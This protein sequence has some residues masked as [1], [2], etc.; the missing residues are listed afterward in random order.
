[1]AVMVLIR[2]E[3][4][5]QW[6]NHNFFFYSFQFFMAYEL[7]VLFAFLTCQMFIINVGS[8]FRML[9]NTVKTFIDPKTS[10]KINVCINFLSYQLYLFI[11]IHS[12]T[13][14][15]WAINYIDVLNLY[16]NSWVQI[17]NFWAT[18][19]FSL[20]CIWAKCYQPC[21]CYVH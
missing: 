16:G 2:K 20:V 10:S 9:W 18:C 17:W 11:L 14:I 8:G 4:P 3:D 15:K 5:F 13:S 6:V 19:M 7:I 21:L 12:S 1:M